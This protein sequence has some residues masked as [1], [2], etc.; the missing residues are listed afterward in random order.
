M[1]DCMS[2]SLKKINNK[3]ISI[4]LLLLEGVKAIICYVMCES[5]MPHIEMYSRK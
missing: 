3:I 5:D 4:T 1:V 2:L